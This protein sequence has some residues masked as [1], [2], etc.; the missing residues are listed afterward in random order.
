MT[1]DGSGSTRRPTTAGSRSARCVR[2]SSAAALRL[3]RSGLSHAAYVTAT[4]IIGLENVLDAIERWR[5][6]F[7]RERGRDPGLYYV[8]V[9]GEPLEHTTWGWRFGG[10]HVSVNHT[11]VDGEL[12]SSTPCFLGADPASAPLLGPHPLRPLAGAEDLGRELVRSLD[13]GQFDRALLSPVAPVDLV[14]ANRPQVGDGDRPLPLAAIFRQ[15]LPA[16]MHDALATSQAAM[17][18]TVGLR[19]EHVDAVALTSTPKGLPAAALGSRPARP[20][21]GAARR[22]R[23]PRA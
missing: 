13:A 3:L 2:L 8:R 1:S 6:T 9:F 23:P 12:A 17:E 20:A 21:A 14:S 19:A 15:P 22:L 10:H 4:T 5:S 18:T 16:P 11:V 7:G